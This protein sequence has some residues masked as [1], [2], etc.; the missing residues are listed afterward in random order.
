MFA[1]LAGL[2]AEIKAVQERCAALRQYSEKLRASEPRPFK[3]DAAPAAT[4][5][6]A[7]AA[8]PP[9]SPQYELG[10]AP[11]IPESSRNEKPK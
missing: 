9:T 1:Q 2:D 7:D 11:N 3:F 4:P 6:A 8:D 10:A 5:S